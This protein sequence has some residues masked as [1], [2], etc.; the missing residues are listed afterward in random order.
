[1]WAYLLAVPI[2]GGAIMVQS[3]VIS[4][5][6]LLHG[7]A[8]LMMLIVAA[9]VIRPRVQ[10]H[11]GWVILA[12]ILMGYTSGLP[13]LLWMAAYAL[14][15]ALALALRKRLLRASILAMLVVTL[16]GT[17][18][19]HVFSYAAIALNGTF[20]PILDVFNQITLPSILLNLFL[21]IPVYGLIGDL[22]ES[23]YPQELES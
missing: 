5:M 17:L 22:A 9:R 2:L 6:P 20:L 11:W 14:M 8:D 1:V 3:A 13:F 21:A 19:T 12:G 16:A 18:L 23:L 7:A 4:R 15:T 10:S